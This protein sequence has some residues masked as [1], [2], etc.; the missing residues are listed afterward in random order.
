MCFEE[1]KDTFSASL[2]VGEVFLNNKNNY[3]VELKA[4]VPDLTYK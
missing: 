3:H 1:L 4:N 2:T